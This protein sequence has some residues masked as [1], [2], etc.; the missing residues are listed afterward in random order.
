LNSGTHDLESGSGKSTPE[1]LNTV[2]D[3]KVDR[4]NNKDEEPLHDEKTQDNLDIGDNPINPSY[5]QWAAVIFCLFFSSIFF[6]FTLPCPFRFV[7]CCAL[8]LH[9]FSFS[10]QTVSLID[11]GGWMK[12]VTGTSGNKPSEDSFPWF[13]NNPDMYIRLLWDLLPSDWRIVCFP[14]IPRNAYDPDEYLKASQIMIKDIT[15]VM[16]EVAP[17]CSFR[18][19][20]G[21]TKQVVKCTPLLPSDRKVAAAWVDAIYAAMQLQAAEEGLLEEETD[22][23]ENEKLH[24]LLDLRDKYYELHPDERPPELE[25]LGN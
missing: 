22:E 2:S 12:T 9:L 18:I 4:G 19:Y 11:R 3:A 5:L 17:S 21:E 25:E 13:Q 20:L 6:I 10:L 14:S 23:E 1:N 16:L 7:S 15:E 8:L 24:G